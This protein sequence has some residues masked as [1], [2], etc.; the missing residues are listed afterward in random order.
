MPS[1]D[2]SMPPDTPLLAVLA[3]LEADGY[4]DQFIPL[5]NGFIRCRCGGHQFVAASS[6]ADQQRR[7][8]GVSDPAEMVI[9]LAFS[10]PVCS[11]EGTL[12]LHYGPE[13]SPEE[14]DTLTALGSL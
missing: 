7:L 5:E 3:G 4:D 1:A 9:V 2:A 11:A 13:A 6:W 8:E 14:T 12:V 10:C